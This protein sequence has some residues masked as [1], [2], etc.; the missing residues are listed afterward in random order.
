MRGTFLFDL[1]FTNSRN[2]ESRDLNVW[3]RPH[4]IRVERAIPYRGTDFR[5]RGRSQRPGDGHLQLSNAEACPT[6]I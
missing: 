3:S 4:R 5:L 6:W 1:H 2:A